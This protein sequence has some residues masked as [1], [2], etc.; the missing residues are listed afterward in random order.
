MSKFSV[1]VKAFVRVEVEAPNADAARK[2]ADEFIEAMDDPVT[3]EIHHYNEFRSGRPIEPHTVLGHGGY[4]VDGSSDVDKACERCG[5]VLD[6]PELAEDEPELC[7]GC[8]PEEQ[9]PPLDTPS[10]DTSF[11][12]HEMDI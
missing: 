10:L 11:H 3:R 7:Y 8:A 2:A 1:D 12:D 4:F 5:E 6:D 9:E